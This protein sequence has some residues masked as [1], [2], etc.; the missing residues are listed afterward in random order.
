MSLKITLAGLCLVLTT[1]CYATDSYPLGLYPTD[2]SKIVTYSFVNQSTNEP[3]FEKLTV[4]Q[5]GDLYLKSPF[6]N[7]EAI[8]EW[9]GPNGFSSYASAIHIENAGFERN[10]VY[11][12]TIHQGSE[13]IAA[14]IMVEVKE[15]PKYK[16]VKLEL[17]GGHRYKVVTSLNDATFAWKNSQG[18]ILGASAWWL[19]REIPSEVAIA[20]AGCEVIQKI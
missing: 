4:C 2:T 10:G 8:Y 18:K 16:I 20:K 3:H 6:R 15:R 11:N 1:C 12:L 14:Q 19:G 13:R 9:S 5:G 17:E 7:M